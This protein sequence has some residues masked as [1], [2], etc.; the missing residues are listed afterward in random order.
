[1]RHDPAPTR[2]IFDQGGRSTLSMDQVL[3][4]LHRL[5]PTVEET[6]ARWI[7]DL[8]L[9]VACL[10]PGLLTWARRVSSPA[11]SPAPAPCTPQAQVLVACLAEIR[12]AARL[13]LQLAVAA[14]A[15]GS[16]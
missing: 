12:P 15:G 5:A 8:D 13:R 11:P 2:P 4:L 10:A 9:L 1:M 3:A 7:L 16:A 6:L 14:G